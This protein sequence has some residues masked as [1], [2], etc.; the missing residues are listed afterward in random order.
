MNSNGTGSDVGR[1]KESL[2][3]R[4]GHELVFEEVAA[5]SAGAGIAEWGS[6]NAEFFWAADR[7]LHAFW[8]LELVIA[9]TCGRKVNIPL[10]SDVVIAQVGRHGDLE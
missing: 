7:R 9:G 8:W 6:Q 5:E 4:N 3:D 1:G 2:R 10:G